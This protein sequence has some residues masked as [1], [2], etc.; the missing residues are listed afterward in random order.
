M[1]AVL[2]TRSASHVAGVGGLGLLA[3]ATM[4]IDA[5]TPYPGTAALVPVAGPL[6]LLVAGTPSEDP[7]W[8]TRGLAS[9]GFQALGRVSCSWYLWHW[10]VI[11]LTVAH[12][13]RDDAPLRTIAAL[14]SLPLAYLAYLAFRFVENPIRF[15]DGPWKR[16]RRTAA[17]GVGFTAAAG[18]AAFGGAQL[19]TAG[20]T[21][22]IEAQVEVA[23][24]TAAGRRVSRSSRP[25]GSP[26]ASARTTQAVRW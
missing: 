3:V 19:A 24:S 10:S 23:R 13:G 11:I 26:I 17:V 21:T 2:R 8:V 12:F 25:T 6:L 20:P 22:P 4:Q 7:T 18:L 1:P 9:A 15:A 16:K 5:S 14:G